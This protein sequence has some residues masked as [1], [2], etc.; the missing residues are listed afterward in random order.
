MRL[1]ISEICDVEFCDPEEGP[2]MCDTFKH[3]SFQP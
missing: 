1:K 2:E 3:N